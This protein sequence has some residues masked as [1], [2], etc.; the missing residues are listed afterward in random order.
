VDPSYGLQ[1]F[2]NCSSMGPFFGLQSFRNRLLH[3]R[4]STGSQVLPE[5][6]L[7]CGLL[8]TGS[9]VLLEACSNTGSPCGHSSFEHPP[10]LAW[11]APQFAGGY[12]VCH[13]PPWAA[14]GLPAFIMVLTTGCR[15]ISAPVPESH[16]PPS[17]SLT[18]IS[19]GL[20][21]SHILTPVQC[22]LLL[23]K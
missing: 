19:A 10:A 11:G 9:H 13:E 12:Q 22:F 4:S 7:Q 14:G 21:L 5:N 15:G 16:P 17:S 23:L 3:P 2:K 6:M 1:F 8:S 18:L 20:L